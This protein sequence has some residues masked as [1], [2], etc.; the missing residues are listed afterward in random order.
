MSI[1]DLFLVADDLNEGQ[2]FLPFNAAVGTGDAYY[3][4]WLQDSFKRQRVLELRDHLLTCLPDI[5]SIEVQL[6]TAP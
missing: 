2:V 4:V 5:S 3:L 1:G 6:L